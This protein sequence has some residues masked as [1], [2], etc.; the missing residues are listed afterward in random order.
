VSATHVWLA[1]LVS[2]AGT[3]A[4]R[5]VFLV[6]A[7]SFTRLP[8]WAHRLLRQIPPAA[9]ASIVAP[10]LLRPEGHLD[11][12]SPEL[13]AGLLAALVAWRTRSTGL[14]LAV[15]MVSLFALRLL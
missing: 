13:A 5:A 12:A 3:Y 10:A 8:P 6:A 15:G 9:L 2:G 11:L 7:G 1:V 4:M 14:T